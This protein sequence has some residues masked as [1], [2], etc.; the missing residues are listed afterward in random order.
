VRW[1]GLQPADATWEDV[2]EFRDRY[3][4][5]ELEDEATSSFR[6]RVEMLWSGACIHGAV[7]SSS[8]EISSAARFG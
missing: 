7:V 1:E 4:A 3:P 2:Q 6:R 8:Q 5:F